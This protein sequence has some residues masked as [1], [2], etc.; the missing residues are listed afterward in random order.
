M[1]FYFDFKHRMCKPFRWGG[2]G[3]NKNNFEN[4]NEC[5]SFCALFI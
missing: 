3:G 4:F 5:L 1:R 2:C